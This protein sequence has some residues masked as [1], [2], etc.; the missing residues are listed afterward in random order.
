MEQLEARLHDEGRALHAFDDEYDCSCRCRE[1]GQAAEA[2]PG[3][4]FLSDEEGD[5]REPVAAAG[6]AA[7]GRGRSRPSLAAKVL[8]I[9]S[10]VCAVTSLVLTGPEQPGR[11]E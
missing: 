10:V 5:D 4:D 8:G 3:D 11:E 6:E 9:L 7:R 1:T 2:A